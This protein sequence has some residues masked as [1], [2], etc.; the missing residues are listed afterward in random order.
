[1]ILDRDFAFL[2]ELFVLGLF[3]GEIES[4]VHF[5]PI[6]FDGQ[7]SFFQRDDHAI[8]LPRRLRHVLAWADGSD[9]SPA[10]MMP[11]R[12]RLPVRIEDLHL[13]SRIHGI[14]TVANPDVNTT[15]STLRVS[16]LEIKNE[17]AVGALQPKIGAISL[18]SRFPGRGS[19][20][21]D[22]SS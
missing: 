4:V 3:R 8:P 22:P 16:V 7:L 20:A 14:R 11:E 18:P 19:R 10:I 13:D 21:T 5:L 15:V 2:G 17:I 12:F 9:D 1:M 6:N